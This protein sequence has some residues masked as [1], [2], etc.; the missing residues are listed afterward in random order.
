MNKFSL[1]DEVRL[2]NGKI[3]HPPIFKKISYFSDPD[4]V[5]RL[6]SQKYHN[7]RRFLCKKN[8]RK[9]LGNNFKTILKEERWSK[10]P[11]FTVQDVVTY[12]TLEYY[13]KTLFL[14]LLFAGQL[15]LEGILF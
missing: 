6:G 7:T 14:P 9:M 11:T 8:G 5:F 2:N 3:D 10:L 12:S 4:R 13:E 15:N 1:V